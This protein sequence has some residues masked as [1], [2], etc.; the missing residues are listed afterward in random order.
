MVTV[1]DDSRVLFSWQPV[2]G[3]E[4]YILQANNLTTGETRIIREDNI[5]PASFLS[6]SALA[7]GN[8]RFWVQAIGDGPRLWSF[9]HDFTV[10]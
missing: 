6:A 2:L 3:A 5:A 7:S 10:E 9:A 4:R 1:V 8:Y